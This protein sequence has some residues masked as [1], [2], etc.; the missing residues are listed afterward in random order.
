MIGR[1]YKLEGGGKFYIGSTTCDL[2]NR[3][4]HH[5]SKSKEKIAEK[6]GLYVHF[7]EIGWENATISVIEE[8]EITS[9]KDLFARECEVIKNYIGIPDCLNKSRPVITKEDKKESD[10]L[11]GKI[12]RKQNMEKERN[13]VKE[14]RKN[15]PD[16]WKAQY[17]RANKKKSNKAQCELN[18]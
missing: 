12:R 10:K 11:Y 6:R 4:K 14:W 3:L 1:I 8:L 9:R 15:N 5:R 18:K 17:D 7:R 2:K 16:K 13:R